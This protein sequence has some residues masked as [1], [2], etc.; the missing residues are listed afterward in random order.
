MGYF[1]P[2]VFLYSSIISF[3]KKEYN[4][5]CDRKK[6][7]NKRFEEEVEKAS[8]EEGVWKVEN[9]ERK[10]RKRVNQKIEVLEWRKHF[11]K[12]LR[13]VKKKITKGRREGKRKKREGNRGRKDQWM[14]GKE[15]GVDEISN[16]V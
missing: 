3:E 8:M 4:E 9:R 7:E 5:L 15:A 13:G 16:E 11:M 2:D 1:P 6:E 12:L 14:V 10:Q